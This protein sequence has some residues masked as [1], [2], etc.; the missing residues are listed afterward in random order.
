MSAIVGIM[1]RQGSI[2]NLSDDLQRALASLTIY[3]PDGSG[4]W[5]GDRMVLGHQQMVITQEDNLERLPS[6][7]RSSRLAITADVRLDNREDLGAIFGLSSAELVCTTDS[8]LILLAYQKWGKACPF[9]LFGDFAFAIWNAAEHTLFCARDHIGAKPFY[10]GLTPQRFI[11]ASDI[12]GVLAVPSVSHQ[13]NEGYIATHLQT[14]HFTH[15]E[16]TFYENIRK[17]PPAHSLTLRD[18]THHL[19]RYWDPEQLPDIHLSS[20]AAYV[21]AFFDIYHRAV[22]AR[23]RTEHPVGMHVSGGLDSSSIVVLASRILR[24]QGKPLNGFCWEPPPH[25]ECSAKDERL[26]IKAICEQEGVSIEYQDLTPEHCLSMLRRNITREPTLDTLLQE[27]R[28]QEQAAK[29]LIRVMLSGWGGDE[30]ITFNGAGHY[31]ELFRKRQ[32]RALSRDIRAPGGKVWK[33]FVRFVLYPLTPMWWQRCMDRLC[34]TL[35][36]NPSPKME[37]FIHPTLALRMKQQVKLLT[38]KPLALVGGRHTQLQLL[39][40]GHLTQRLENWAANSARYQM[41]YHY[42]LLDRRIVEF[43]LGLPSEFFLKGKWD[44][45]F[46]R[47]AMTDLL[48]TAVVWNRDKSDPVRT[49]RFRAVRQ[50]ALVSLGKQIREGFTLPS[51][52]VYLDT[53]RLL[54]RLTSERAIEVDEARS[55]WWAMQF[56]GSLREVGTTQG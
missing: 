7:D 6:Y 31:V 13:F 21:E 2:E 34:P 20:E 18:N 17:L 23:L 15:N 16:L 40:L 12:N 51:R 53:E 25:T 4:I 47:Q 3:G 38:P 24:Q 46:A 27:E 35:V 28:V 9:H 1:Q 54:G 30:L 32:W 55:L 44:R 43:A 10:Y 37:S 26:L 49:E 8:A 50:E 48:P 42:P 52:A 39:Q 45:W 11:F 22:E 19:E 14:L 29:H 36:S 33:R 5:L 41:V 56:L